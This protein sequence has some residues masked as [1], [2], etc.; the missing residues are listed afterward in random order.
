VIE[1]QGHEPVIAILG[2]KFIEGDSRPYQKFVFFGLAS[3]KATS[4][5]LNDELTVTAVG[6]SDMNSSEWEERLSRSYTNTTT[7]PTT[8]EAMERYAVGVTVSD[9]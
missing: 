5:E 9:D 6:E 4:I 7:F 3:G 8:L 2:T 1:A